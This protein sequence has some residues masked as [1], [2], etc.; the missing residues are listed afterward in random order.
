MHEV[1]F[2]FHFLKFSVL[3]F[4]TVRTS[5]WK[6]CCK[7]DIK[8]RPFVDEAKIEINKQ[9]TEKEIFSDKFR[10]IFFFSFYSILL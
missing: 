5:T 6:M 3:K 4:F 9:T 8:L 1:F 7:G 10:R 2:C